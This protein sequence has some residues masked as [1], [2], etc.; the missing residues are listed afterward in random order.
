MYTAEIRNMCFL[1]P[2]TAIKPKLSMNKL[3]YNSK[4]KGKLILKNT[5]WQNNAFLR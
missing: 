4:A 2:S 3:M 5:A 1:I